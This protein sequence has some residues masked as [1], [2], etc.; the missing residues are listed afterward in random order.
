MHLV[1][2]VS[3]FLVDN[4][5]ATASS[6]F[7]RSSTI[8]DVFRWL[9]A[10]VIDGLARL[11]PEGVARTHRN[12]FQLELLNPGEGINGHNTRFDRS[13]GR[14]LET[15]L[16]HSDSSSEVQF[17]LLHKREPVDFTEL[18]SAPAPRKPL[19]AV[20]LTPP[21]AATH[22]AAAPGAAAAQAAATPSRQ[23]RRGANRAAAVAAA[24]QDA[25]AEAPLTAAAA[26]EAPPAPSDD[27][28]DI[29]VALHS[30]A[31]ARQERAE[32]LASTCLQDSPPRSAEQMPPPQTTPA[33]AAAAAAKVQTP[34]EGKAP[35]RT[36][37]S[38]PRQPRTGDVEVVRVIGLAGIEAEMRSE[39]TTST[40][41]ATAAA[42][43]PAR[44]SPYNLGI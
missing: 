10:I 9:P 21:P 39:A 2:Q 31:A 44:A 11:C 24:Q 32:K 43:S 8:D 33:R 34:G 42:A 27:D 3:V 4:G 30:R 23:S 28:A 29:V 41:T 14:R 35:A 15:A 38:A 40:A 13:D 17:R 20:H 22:G 26:A 19:S 36:P 7:R 16:A 12:V 6:L 1:L 18:F 5:K 25:A 37:G